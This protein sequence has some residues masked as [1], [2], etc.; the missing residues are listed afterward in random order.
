VTGEHQVEDD[1]IRSFL[2]GGAQRVR[3]GAGGGDPIP[4]FCEVVRDERGDIGLVVDDENAGWGGLAS[5]ACG[6][7]TIRSHP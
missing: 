2:T 1:E 4:F 5:A 7:G 3:A 6:G